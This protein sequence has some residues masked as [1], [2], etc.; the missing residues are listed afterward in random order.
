LPP[1]INRKHEGGGAK[2]SPFVF[3]TATVVNVAFSVSTILKSLPT[4]HSMHGMVF[5]YAFAFRKHNYVCPRFTCGSMGVR[6]A[7]RGQFTGA[8]VN[9]R[10]ILG[11][12]NNAALL[13]SLGLIYDILSYRRNIQTPLLDRIVSGVTTGA[14]AVALMATPVI[15]GPGI[16]FDT[17]TILLGLT[18]LFFG[19]IPT[20]IAMAIAGAYRLAL[21][22]GGTA[23]GITTIVL[24][25]AC[26]L[27]WRHYRLR[28]AKA[29][30]FGELYLFGVAVH[31]GMIL[32]ML[33]LPTEL[34]AR[35]MA[36]LA[37]PVILIYPLCT[38]LLGGLLS[39]RH[40][41]YQLEK[42]LEESAARY[43][44]LAA[45]SR[46]IT[47]EIDVTGLFTYVSPVVESVF[48]YLPHELVGT[49]RF[50]EI[51]PTEGRERFKT[52]FLELFASK[53][54]VEEVVHPVVTV[55][56]RTIWMS[57]N[58]LPIMDEHGTLV[59]YRGACTDISERKQLEDRLRESEL[60]HRT[61]FE[62]NPYGVVIIDPDSA[63]LIDFNDQACRQ[64]GYTREEF[65]RLKISDIDIVESP[66]EIRSH[67]QNILCRGY[68]EFETLQRTKQGE[69]RS[70]L[71]RAQ[72]SHIKGKNV[73]H[74]IWRDITAEK[75]E[76]QL[77][78]AR[79]HLI[80]YSV[81]H[82][83]DELLTETLDRLEELTGS[84]LGF[85]HLLQEDQR[86]ITLH[87]WSSRTAEL[88]TAECS[89]RHYDI[90]RAGV[91]TDCASLRQPVIHNDYASLP[92]RKGLPA[93]HAPVNRQ[94]TMPIMRHDKIAGILGIGNKKTDYTRE[95][96]AVVSR[97]A[98]LV[99]DIAERKQVHDSLRES[100]EKFS[101]AF[102]N[103]P[104][105]ITISTIEDGRYLDVN[106]RFLDISGFS[107]EEVLANTAVSLGWLGASDRTR[108]KEMMLK[109][110]SI[111]DLE[112]ETRSKSG[113]KVLC[114]YWGTIIPVAG[115][116]RLL[117][118]ALDITEHRR[119]EQQLFQAQKMDSIGRLAG[120]VAHDFNNMLS[121]I[122]GRSELALMQTD[123]DNP[124]YHNLE[125]I[126]GAA[127]RSAE[128]TKQL[129]TFSRKQTIVPK[130]LDLNDTITSMLKML[131]RLLGEN[132]K[133]GW[134][135]GYNLR[136]VKIDP[137]QLDQILVNLCV[138]ARDAI[139][140]TGEINIQ[141]SNGTFGEASGTDDIPPGDYVLLEV[142]DTGC[143]IGPELLEHIFE[144]FFTTK[145]LGHGTGL[146]LA[147]VY[148]IVQQCGGQIRVS[149]LPGNGSTFRIYFPAA[150][151]P[152][153]API[154]AAPEII[155]GTET[156]LFVEDETAIMHMGAAMLEK[157][158]Y[159]V[160]PVNSPEEAQ[161]IAVTH[162][163]SINLLITDV[164]MPGMNGHDLAVQLRAANPDMKI[165][166][167][168]GYT[169]DILSNRSEL[170][171]DLHFL[172]KP[173]TITTLD[174]K[175]REALQG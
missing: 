7:S 77:L 55:D 139:A 62:Q 23:M 137:S 174:G 171:Q 72:Y 15:F 57:T 10:I 50:Y 169:S 28:Q 13:L 67:I 152:T 20:V 48:G 26:G 99:W 142:S 3:L 53:T 143:G 76:A 133:L 40:K 170:G 31:L 112:L 157:L 107:R 120:G 32:C 33:L 46:T 158:G 124:L 132:I 122:I 130:V 34:I 2:A 149:S 160:L 144:P 156:I 9:E 74:C 128:I 116:K 25:G 4:R 108:L 81:S 119:M 39:A 121:I 63:T 97:F 113:A 151:A 19:T 101:S 118:I 166:F 87:A 41:K 95:D 155:G 154:P 164:I 49:M 102:N 117:S 148:G 6:G 127:K 29:F 30:S 73:Y 88:C 104:L 59:G 51:H 91:W 21:G 153:D 98:D 11:L 14:I 84:E 161:Q 167:M 8:M 168:S 58:A 85:F 80:E 65:S 165:L 109:N 92:H 136:R 56:G 105:M 61:L 79:T 96:I 18:G 60:L 43:N 110:G 68:D 131:R 93:G 172:Q 47:W 66:D 78:L 75:K 114:K 100:D 111:Q 115:R 135:P 24:S 125:E 147:T 27:A 1:S 54:I 145:E 150:S 17:R 42:E 162:A 126:Q 134:N 89:H 90:S 16:I 138:N 83:L 141:T 38:A 146:G 45:Q 173:F 37:L 86:T 71:V 159:R 22:G 123:R 129:L 35:T 140:G 44:Q 12:V 103:A 94:L 5:V 69:Q 82:S 52:S 175:I 163:G 70:I 106:Q 36:S 64:L